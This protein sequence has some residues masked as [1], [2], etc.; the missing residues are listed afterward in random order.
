M[1]QMKLQGIQT[2]IHYPP[3]HS[4]QAYSD[5]SHLPLPVT[6]DVAS[7]EVTLP[8]FALLT[9]DQVRTVAQAVQGALIEQG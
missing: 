9:Q 1:D 8:L 5:I 4:F 7:R 3:I 6:E 2:S